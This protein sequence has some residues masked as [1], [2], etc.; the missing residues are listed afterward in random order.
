M[1]VTVVIIAQSEHQTRSNVQLEHFP[2]HYKMKTLATAKLV[3]KAVTVEREVYQH[4][5]S[6]VTRDIIV[7]LGNPPN[8]L[9]SSGVRPVIIALTVALVNALASRVVI[10][11]NTANGNVKNVLLDFIV[12]LAYSMPLIVCMESNY[13]HHVHRDIIVLMV[14][15][16]TS[17]MDVQ[18]VCITFYI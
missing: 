15:L 16:N 12:M 18:M 5:P 8:D 4:L 7:R 3:H 6:N 14:L 11:T 13:L 9:Q 2:I 17:L 10:K 1:F